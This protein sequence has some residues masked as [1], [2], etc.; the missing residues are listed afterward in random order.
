MVTFHGFTQDS[1]YLYIILEFIQGGEMFTH[2]RTVGKF[3][4]PK[5]K[6]YAASVTSMF[7]YMHNRDII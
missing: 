4:E 3:E 7:E 6:F 2:L 5:S 1:R